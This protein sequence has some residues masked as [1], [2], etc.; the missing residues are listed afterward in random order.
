MK[1][2]CYF[3]LALVK[4]KH[5]GPSDDFSRVAALG[6]KLL[7]NRELGNDFWAVGYQQNGFIL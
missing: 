7:R 2:T 1:G 4:S 5:V 6:K 3:P